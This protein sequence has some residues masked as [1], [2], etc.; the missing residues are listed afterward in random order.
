MKNQNKITSLYSASVAIVALAGTFLFLV[1]LVQFAKAESLPESLAEISGVPASS[2]SGNNS[3]GSSVIPASSNSTNTYVPTAS[4]STNNDFGGSVPGASNST[5][6]G[7]TATPAASNSTN[8]SGGSQSAPASS[9][10]NNNSSG[11]ATNGPPAPAASGGGGGGGGGSAGNGPPFALG[12]YLSQFKASPAV[13]S[14]SVPPSV[15]AV[16]TQST[17]AKVCKSYLNDY[18]S[19][20]AKNNPAEVTK[21]QQFLT[22]Q[23]FVVDINGNYDEKT[24]K[25]VENFQLKYANDIL[26]KS[27]GV[28]SPTGEVYITTK[29][30]INDLVCGQARDFKTLSYLGSELV[31]R[32]KA[33]AL[34]NSGLTS[35]NLPIPNSIVTSGTGL[36][37]SNSSNTTVTPK[38]SATSN[39]ATTS[40]LAESSTS[41]RK[42][43]RTSVAEAFT[44]LWHQ[45]G[46]VIK[47][48]FGR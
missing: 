35:S 15:S 26:N 31:A 29:L 7:G 30:K 2:G 1:F 19:P 41:T 5:N 21:L 46:A 33:L 48:V 25:A 42:N 36:T 18:L 8:N 47:S 45:F 12:S 23:G 11:G 10:S 39:P 14:V 13:N 3:S 43:Q 34:K 40:N 4:N 17:A 22:E 6:S 37:V 27:W 20:K 38:V 9:N 32:N 24:T 44:G 16:N 28:S